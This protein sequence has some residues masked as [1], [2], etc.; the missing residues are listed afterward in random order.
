M[1]NR[2]SQVSAAVGAAAIV[3]LGA[4]VFGI[5]AGPADAQQPAAEPAV[6]PAA[7]VAPAPRAMLSLTEIERLVNAQGLRVTEL[8]VKDSVVEVE[9][10]D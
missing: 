7:A 10:R 9:G 3:T 8:E 6:Q 4:A 5:F 1:M 2:I